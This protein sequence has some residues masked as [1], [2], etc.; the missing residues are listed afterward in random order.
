VFFESNLT[1]KSSHYF[2]RRGRQVAWRLIA[3]TFTFHSLTLSFPLLLN[4]FFLQHRISLRWLFAHVSLLST[5]LFL[6]ISIQCSFQFVSFPT[7]I[8]SSLFS[9]LVPSFCDMRF[10][11]F[12]LWPFSIFALLSLECVLFRISCYFPLFFS[13][14]MPPFLAFFEM[15]VLLYLHHFSSVYLGGC[16]LLTP[17][18]RPGFPRIFFSRYVS[19]VS[20]ACNDVSVGC[21]PLACSMLQWSLI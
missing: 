14:L 18:S 1:L 8:S 19:C 4:S 15:C 13:F 9:K 10:I 6:S 5:L 12:V 11:S 16:V 20:G 21:D 2:C 7:D 3:C 17:S